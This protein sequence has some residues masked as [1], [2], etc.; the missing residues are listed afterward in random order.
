MSGSSPSTYPHAEQVLLDGYQRDTLTNV[1]PCQAH[2]YPS[3]LI[4][5]DIEAS[6]TAFARW[7]F[8]SMPRT[9]R[10]STATAWLSRT[11]LV[12]ALCRASLRWSAI[13]SCTRATLTRCLA[14]LLD[15]LLLRER[16][17]CSRASL[18][19][20]LAS[21]FGLATFSPVLSAARLAMPASTPI[22]GTAPS[23][24]GATGA[25]ATEST[26][27]YLPDG[28]R[29]TVADRMRPSTGLL[30]RAFT[31]PSFGSFTWR[32]SGTA[33][34]PPTRFER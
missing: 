11:I 10:S 33:T 31:R 3:F 28:A 25:S 19:S 18:A 22:T 23:G 17:R 7:R 14:C 26:Q 32:A 2:L 30:T 12:V 34:L 20:D 16:R 21:A 9:P 4:I 1:R 15:P 8:R 27:K 13:L 5:S 24:I 29:F 6:A